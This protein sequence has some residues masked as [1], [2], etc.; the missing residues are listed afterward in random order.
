M[1]KL[2]D[3]FPELLNQLSSYKVHMAISPRADNNPLHAF[4][5]GE[6]KQWQEWQTKKNFER[7]YILS[8]IYYQSTEWLYAG[9]YKSESSVYYENEDHYEYDTELTEIRKD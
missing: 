9:I 1:L 3:L 5:R 7:P 2:I 8:L 4:F 6:F